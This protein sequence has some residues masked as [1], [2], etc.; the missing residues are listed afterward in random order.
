MRDRP[1]PFSQSVAENW[2]AG[3]RFPA[4]RPYDSNQSACKPGSVPPPAELMSADG[5]DDHSSGTPLAARLV[6]PTRMIRPGGGPGANASSSLFGFAPG[7]V[8]RAASVARRAVRSY[9]TLS[10]LPHLQIR[11]LSTGRFAFCGTFPGVTPAG[12]YPAPCFHGA[13]TFLSAIAVRNTL[14]ASRSG[15]PANWLAKN[16]GIRRLQVKCDA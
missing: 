16:K 13:R 3:P 5:M 11:D 2:K 8:Y 9:R 1:F 6:Q 10:P 12:R 15:H 4:D 7:G 14:P